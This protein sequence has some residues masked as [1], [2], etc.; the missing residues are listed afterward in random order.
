M[1]RFCEYSSLTDKHDLHVFVLY[2]VCQCW[3]E[4]A[5]FVYAYDPTLQPKLQDCITVQ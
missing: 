4:W 3:V 1:R 5:W 2:F